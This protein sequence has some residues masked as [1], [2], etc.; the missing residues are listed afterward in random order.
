M[1]SAGSWSS[2]HEELKKRNNW[3]FTINCANS[4]YLRIGGYNARPYSLEL[5]IGEKIRPSKLKGYLRWWFRVLKL[6]Q[7]NE[8]SNYKDADAEIEK[9]LGSEKLGQS[10]I[11]IN[12]RYDVLK[13]AEEFRE[14][15][16]MMIDNYTSALLRFKENYK[17]HDLFI[18]KKI[19]IAE[20]D[21]HPAN[22]RIRFESNYKFEPYKNQLVSHVKK[23]L[24]NIFNINFNMDRD[25]VKYDRNKNKHYLNI[26][27]ELN[28]NYK[29]LKDLSN[30]P[31]IKLILMERTEEKNNY[32]L[33]IKRIK[34]E[35]ALYPP[36][37]VNVSI[38]L[39]SNK[40]F[41][42]IQIGK[43]VLVNLLV[44]LILML[45][46]TGL[47]AF[48]L[49]GFAGVKITALNVNDKIKNIIGDV[50]DD[51]IKIIE[52][53]N[54][55]DTINNLLKKLN[56]Q[57]LEE[58]PE[59]PTLTL[60]LE[61]FRFKIFKVKH[62][63][64]ALELL[65]VIN[66]SVMK[67]T[68]KII[69]KKNIRSAGS[70]YHTW[71]LGLPRSQR[72]TGYIVEGKRDFRRKS[73]IGINIFENKSGRFI[74]VHGFLSSDWPVNKLLHYSERNYGEYVIDIMQ[75]YSN[76]KVIQKAFDQA[77]EYVTKHIIN[78]LR[79]EK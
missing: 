25:R 35:L 67:S 11:T 72:N 69:D 22:P 56:L 32:E 3:I 21:F 50:Y 2:I 14:K 31:R 45:I 23:E 41:D 58:I 49:R 46:F 16:F 48:S 55:E 73:A 37:T 1:Y 44:T 4:S 71:I 57:V 34:E 15:I 24:N 29:I 7:N 5:N 40:P 74:V 12:V 79:I 78:E 47:S 26:N 54:L 17:K 42:I 33:Y 27:L 61:N 8:L 59:T 9:Y 76:E 77:F 39:F 6:G 38:S 64:N 65:T 75:E 52:A 13:E 62:E 63:E 66:K 36:Y 53:E 43:D 20:I 28:D 30:I 60:D 70:N 10:Q 18:N 51:C 68:W 19:E